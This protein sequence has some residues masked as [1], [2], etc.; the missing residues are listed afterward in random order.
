[1][2]ACAGWESAGLRIET[3]S[4]VL[5]WR[6]SWKPNSGR[7]R[8]AHVPV[9]PSGDVACTLVR[10]GLSL[11]FGKR[12]MIH[13]QGLP[14]NVDGERKPSDKLRVGNA[15]HVLLPEHFQPLGEPL[16]TS[17]TARA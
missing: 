14:L 5:A 4:T 2:D 3:S 7:G 12:S 6:G 16:F 1:M 10:D 11:P 13:S 8:I 15:L 9:D 17:T